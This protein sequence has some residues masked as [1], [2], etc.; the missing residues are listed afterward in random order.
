M[1]P[2]KSFVLIAAFFLII[3]AKSSAEDYQIEDTPAVSVSPSFDPYPDMVMP[4]SAPLTIDYQIPF[5]Y[6]PVVG[7]Y[8]PGNMVNPYVPLTSGFNPNLAQNSLNPVFN[9]ELAGFTT[10]PFF[11]GQGLNNPNYLNSLNSLSTNFT[12]SVLPPTGLLDKLQME[13]EIRKADQIASTK[14][15]NYQDK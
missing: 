9:P 11:P 10:N 5:G 13:E 8:T 12:S 3:F 6:Q 14:I 4:S 1:V 7:V 2:N 15:D